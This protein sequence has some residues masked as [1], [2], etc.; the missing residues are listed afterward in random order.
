MSAGSWRAA[1]AAV[2][3]CG[4]G[5]NQFTPLLVMYREAGWSALTVNALL[6]AY[7][8]GLVPGLLV[9]ATLAERWGRRR[10]VTAGVLASLGASLLLAAGP[11]GVAWIAAGRFVTGTAVAV[12]MAV[13]T[14]WVL[15]LSR[16][17]GTDP[18]TGARRGAMWLTLGF[19]AGP[20]V[21]GLLA[22]WGPLPMVL[23][24]LVHAVLALAVLPFLP[25]VPETG[26]IG[27]RGR[28][29]RFA[30]VRH[31]RFLR[32]VV[33]MAPWIFGSAGVAYAIMPQLVGDRLGSWGLAYSTLL[34]VA[35]LGA[36]ALVQ[37]VA[38][39]LDSTTSARAVAVSMVVM[40]AGLALST[41]AAVVRSP[42]VALV[43]AVALG[44]AYGI[45]VVS[46]LLELQRLA[47][48][49]ELA[50]LTGVYYVLAYI[51]FLLPTLLALLSRAAPYPVLLA[52]LALVA[53]AGTAVVLR[54]SRSDLP[55]EH[56]LDASRRREQPA[57][58]AGQ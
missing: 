30:G 36:G 2:F 37:P 33:P 48:P 51:G 12:A 3:A 21:A 41:V 34:T 39:R 24:Y 8:V 47:R 49:E 22:Q 23:P 7:V 52:G 13:G 44:A 20:G 29:A 43:A 9:A 31:P 14:T 50:A 42:V 19:A 53:L 26:R 38:K 45:A 57:V 5:G 56:G 46:G 16:A 10:V 32:V 11:L 55:G 28:G 35:T 54:H 58:V 17:A 25:G 15:E 40:S 27:T 18:G 4:W 6:G 1:A